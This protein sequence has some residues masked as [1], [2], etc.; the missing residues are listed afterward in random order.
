M[1]LYLAN[2]TRQTLKHCYRVPGVEKSRVVIVPSGQQVLMQGVHTQTDVD[3][4]VHDLERYGAR[5]AKELNGKTMK[6]F[7]GIIYSIDK[8]V[9]VENFE[10]GNEAVID[11]AQRRA[12]DEAVKSAQAFDVTQRDKTTRKRLAKVTEVTVQQELP[13]GQRPTADDVNMKVTVAE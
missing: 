8:P 6:S 11:H 5:S 10:I 4:V 1:D 7:P 2:S 9:S 12:A 13:R 3:H